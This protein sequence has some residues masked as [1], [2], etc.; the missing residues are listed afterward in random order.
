MEEFELTSFRPRAKPFEDMVEN[1]RD[2]DHILITKNGVPVA[3]IITAEHHLFLKN[4][5]EN[6][7]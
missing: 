6:A 5:L 2:E 7:E 3:V 1:L 4:V